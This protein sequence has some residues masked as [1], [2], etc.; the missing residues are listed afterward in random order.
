MSENP[1]QVY[2]NASHLIRWR[3]M[4]DRVLMETYEQG[5]ADGMKVQARTFVA[6]EQGTYFIRSDGLMKRLIGEQ[7]FR[8]QGCRSSM[9]GTH[10][11]ALE[12]MSWH[13][14][15]CDDPDVIWIPEA[16]R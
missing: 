10:Q 1:S 4:V 6:P 16:E 7:Y 13:R 12:T 9:W 8:C 5:F 14:E 2:L 15:S 3:E 11:E